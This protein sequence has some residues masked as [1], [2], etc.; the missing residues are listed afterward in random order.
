MAVLI[1]SERVSRRTRR[2]G[3]IAGVYWHRLLLVVVAEGVDYFTMEVFTC[4][5]SVAVAKA[6]ITYHVTR[7]PTDGLGVVQSMQINAD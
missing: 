1:R 6:H 4:V 3:M 2:G 5:L 7:V